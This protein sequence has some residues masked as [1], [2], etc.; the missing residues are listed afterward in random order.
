MDEDGEHTF[1]LVPRKEYFC[2]GESRRG[3]AGLVGAICKV[4]VDD[5]VI[6]GRTLK[7]LHCSGAPVGEAADA[8]THKCNFF[9]GTGK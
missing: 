6:Q 5:I 7:Y 3:L 9:T 4:W 1:A 8:A 2:R